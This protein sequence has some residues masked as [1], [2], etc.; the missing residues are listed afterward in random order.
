MNKWVLET[1]PMVRRRAGKTGEESSELS[2]VCHR[3]ELQGL[4]GINPKTGL[5][6]RQEMFD[7]MADVLVQIECSLRTLNPSEAELAAFWERHERKTK[8]MADWEALYR[9]E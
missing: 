5:T 3:I 2:Q 9:G 6:N 1:D 7:E 4:L 8:N